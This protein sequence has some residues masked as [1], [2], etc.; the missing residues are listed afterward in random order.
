ML[1]APPRCGL[2]FYEIWAEFFPTLSVNV[3]R[4]S[5]PFFLGMFGLLCCEIVIAIFTKTNF[6]KM[7]FTRNFSEINFSE[8]KNEIVEIY[9]KF[10]DGYKDTWERNDSNTLKYNDLKRILSEPRTCYFQKQ[11]KD[12]NRDNYKHKIIIPLKGDIAVS[13]IVVL[14]SHNFENSY[15]VLKSKEIVLIQPPQTDVIIRNCKFIFTDTLENAGSSNQDFINLY[16]EVDALNIPVSDVNK[17][18]DKK[19]WDNYVNALK[20][21]VKKKEEIWKI[22][23]IGNTYREKDNVY[24]DI[25]ISEEELDNKFEDELSEYFPESDIEDYSVHNKKGFIEF[26]TFR[27]LS[28][29]EISK[30]SEMSNKYFFDISRK[31]P[32]H[33][34]SGSVNFKYSD[35]DSKKEILENISGTLSD[36]YDLSILFE[37]DGSFDPKG[38]FDV[39]NK[40]INDN[41]S[42]VA[43]IKSTNEIVLKV[44]RVISKDNLIRIKD[45]LKSL[46]LDRAKVI[47]SDDKSLMKIEVSAPIKE[48]ADRINSEFGLSLVDTIYR[49][50]DGK[51]NT[52]LPQ[53]DGFR[54]DNGEYQTSKPINDFKKQ[55]ISIQDKTENILIKQLPTRYVFWFADNDESRS[56]WRRV[57][58]QNEIKNKADFDIRKREF[59]INA[60]DANEYVDILKQLKSSDFELENKPFKT[61]YFVDFNIPEENMRLGILK[62]IENIMRKDDYNVDYDHLNEELGFMFDFDFDD[63]I[64]RDKFKHKFVEVCSNYKDLINWSFENELGRTRY[65]FVKNDSLESERQKEIANNIRKATFIFLTEEQYKTLR[66]KI[67]EFGDDAIFREG[68]KIG[69]LSKKKGNVLT[70]KIEDDFDDFVTRS[71]DNIDSIRQGYIKPIFPGELVNIERMIKAMAKVTSPGEFRKGLGKIGYPINKNLPNFLFDPSYVRKSDDNLEEVKTRILRNLNEPLLSNNPRQLDAVAKS[72][73]ALDMAIIQGPPG[74]GKTTVIAEIIWQTLLENPYAKILVTSQTNLAVDNALERLKGKKLVRPIRVGKTE[75]FEDEG[76][77]YSFERI[78]NWINSKQNSQEQNN[79]KNAVNQ[80]IDNICRQASYEEDYKEIVERWKSD[81]KSNSDKVKSVFADSYKQNVNVLACTCSECGS[82]NFESIY[83]QLFGN[84]DLSFDV[85]IMDEASKATPPEL[86]LPLTLGKKVIIIG[87]HKQLPPM[88]DEMEFSEALESVGAKNLVENWTKDDYKISQF[89]KL[90]K[91]APSEIVA[92]LDIQFRMHKQIMD[93]IS[94]FY[95]DELENGLVCGIESRMDV[96]DFNEKMSRKHGFRIDPFISPDTHVVWVN[97]ETPEEKVGTSYKN[98]GEIEAINLVLKAIKKADGFKEYFDFFQREED[99]EI[100]IIT[101]YM[102]QMQQIRNSIYSCLTKEQWRN[103]EQNKYINE[104]QIPFRIN[105]VDRFQ[106]M[107]R[108]IIIVSTVRSN[109]QIN[110]D[111]RKIKNDNYPYALGFARELQR[112]NVGFSRAKRL[113]IVIGNEK[114]FKHKQEYAEAIRKM[115]RIDVEQLKNL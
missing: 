100:G 39:V 32:V 48:V 41:F 1:T 105:T 40:C 43:S 81:L 50:G 46:N 9:L 16:K 52:V 93:C 30:L 5:A 63:E 3:S 106:G 70:F 21:L 83:S 42:K 59:R 88:L 17:E 96:D 28:E 67:E 24:I 11:K 99:K 90:F 76:K 25:T 47:L 55:L 54:I 65:E 4:W 85:V 7:E 58:V 87:D 107:E 44:K 108:N 35:V 56:F 97:V 57:K 75:K 36:E 22:K 104:F 101:Y 26:S 38:E 23:K 103:F 110:Q 94:Q 64:Q 34:L 73:S 95:K 66:E 74:T 102:P 114:H 80:W 91:N 82:R 18:N 31:S 98:M 8:N 15:F 6:N 27:I 69:N 37:S 51:G 78:D 12:E 79:S 29:Q 45:I 33:Y 14:S 71:N 2:L 61:Q 68:K 10:K 92:S 109:I 72:I 111:G 86:V 53:I 20:K 62:S 115:H 13:I 77:V 49:F 60:N 112:V 19:I 84:N 113:L 89:E